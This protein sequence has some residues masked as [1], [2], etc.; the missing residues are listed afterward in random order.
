MGKAS[1]ST[2]KFQKNH[3]KRTVDQRKTEQKYKQKFLKGKKKFDKSYTANGEDDAENENVHNENEVFENG[4]AESFFNTMI[5]PVP[6]SNNKKTKPKSKANGKDLE[7]A[8][9]D[10]ED[11]TENDPEFYNYLNENDEDFD[12]NS[13]KKD[14]DKAQDEEEISKKTK[15]EDVPSEVTLKTIA[16]WKKSLETQH[17]AKT[18][19]KVLVSFKYAVNASK[20]DMNGTQYTITD[21]EVFNSLLSL[22]L[23]SIPDSVQHNIPLVSSSGTKQV[24]TESKQFTALSSSLK[25]HASVLS[26]LLKDVQDKDTATLTLKSIHKLLPYISSFRKPLKE[27][28]EA[29]VHI[30]GSA[31]NAEIRNS[32]FDFLK[33]V[34][35]ENSKSLLEP[36]LKSTYNGILKNSR[37]TNIHTMAG[38]NFQKDTAATLF[39]IDPTLSYE[40]GFQFIRQLAVHLRSSIENKTS[41]SYKTIYNWQYCH[42]LDFW[43]R[44]LAAQCDTTKEALSGKASPLRELIYHLVQVTLGAI[45]LIPTPQYFPLRFYLIRGLLRLSQSTG[46]YI[47]LLPLLTEVLSSSVITSNPKNSNLKALDFDH[48]IRASKE[49]LGTRIYQDGVSDEFTDLVGEFFVLYSK[50]IAFPELAAPAIITFKRFTKRSKNTRFNKQLQRL[51]DKLEENT[52]FIQQKRNSVNF[53]PTH[54]AEAAVF[55]KDLALEKTPLG[56][57]VIGQ[58]QVKAEK[59]R[60]LREKLEA[61]EEEESD[62]EDSDEEMSD[63]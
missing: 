34:G 43:S 61:D 8:K 31:E 48:T 49:Y 29:A 33:T 62:A 30:W 36:I 20:P 26:A 16:T 40:L 59:A 58:R 44:T 32:A 46:V 18:I 47:P 5:D 38:I 10:Y 6:K 27:L 14:E 60:A 17:S 50:S 37:S 39:E 55:L 56:I 25:S 19:K 11:M 41:E 9:K 24:S 63:A 7:S 51:V 22:T 45:R 54:K 35:E 2:K 28:I 23:K 12:L 15:E 42:S 4:S 13:N 3:L 53:S 57:H 52:K 1:K 21:P